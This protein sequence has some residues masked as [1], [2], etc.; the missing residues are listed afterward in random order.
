MRKTIALAA[1]LVALLGLTSLAT[2]QAPDQD[3]HGSLTFFFGE[4][5][6]N[7]DLSVDQV[8][9]N[10]FSGDCSGIGMFWG[11]WDENTLPIGINEAAADRFGGN[12]RVTHLT[13]YDLVGREGTIGSAEY[14]QY[15]C[16]APDSEPVF[17][18]GH[19]AFWVAWFDVEPCI[20]PP[21]APVLFDDASIVSPGNASDTGVLLRSTGWEVGANVY[22]CTPGP[23]WGGIDFFVPEGLTFAGLTTLSTDFMPQD[24]D[25]TCVGGSPR[26]QLK[27]DENNN[28]IEEPNATDGNIFVY[29]GTDSGAPACTTG[30]QSTTNLLQAGRTVDSGQ[31]TGGAYGQAYA[32]AVTNFG[33]L[34]IWSISLVVDAGW[35]YDPPGD[36]EH[37]FFI[38]NTNINGNIFDYE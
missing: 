6:P 33:A 11:D 36:E 25:D 37:S 28:S 17:T 24:A 9:A 20:P 2:A 12:W 32:T 3:W 30:W 34:R 5:D 26:F 35:A 15:P 16:G 19:I 14:S 13:G 18:F 27:I 23:C 8:S 10:L 7:E 21:P 38:D 29:F 31:L 4:C 1:G 22:G